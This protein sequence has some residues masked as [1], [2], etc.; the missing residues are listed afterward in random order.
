MKKDSKIDQSIFGIFIN[1]DPQKVQF[2]YE[3][4]QIYINHINI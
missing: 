2:L 1:P 4:K 3:L